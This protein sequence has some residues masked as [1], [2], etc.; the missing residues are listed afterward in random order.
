M[1]RLIRPAWALVLAGTVSC[2]TRSP[3]EGKSVAELEQMLEDASPAVQ[4]QGALG[5]SRLGSEAKDAVPALLNTL[6]RPNALVRE[7][8]ALALGRIGSPEAL[9]GLIRALRDPEWTVRRHAALALG[10]I[11]AATPAVR[12]ALEELQGDQEPLVRQAAE[13]ALRQFAKSES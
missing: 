3:Y 10:R 12:Q 4:A 11:G 9:P 5:L 13:E 6:T 2:G 1:P 7:H 8:A